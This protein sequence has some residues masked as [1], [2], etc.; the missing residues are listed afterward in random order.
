[1]SFADA[2]K[3]LEQYMAGRPL[4]PEQQIII[5]NWEKAVGTEVARCFKDGEF[6]KQFQQHIPESEQ[7][8]YVYNTTKNSLKSHI[9]L[10]DNY[11]LCFR[12]SIVGKQAK[13]EAFWTDNFWVAFNGLSRELPHNSPRRIYSEILVTSKNVLSRHETSDEE[14]ILL[15]QKYGSGSSDGEIRISPKPFNIQQN[16]L[17]TY[18]PECEMEKYYEYQDSPNA[19]S[20]E[21]V[22]NKIMNYHCQKEAEIE[23]K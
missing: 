9:K 14:S 10:D 6:L 20:K 3:D 16:C 1:M 11:V 21:E 19:M 23:I 22:L 2:F 15:E 18:K 5:A 4:E 8:N 13:P 7:F 12:R 17:F